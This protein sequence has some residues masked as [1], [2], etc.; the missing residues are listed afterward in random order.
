MTAR[1][2]VLLCAWVLW[3]QIVTLT[4]PPGDPSRL[5]LPGPWTLDSAYTFRATCLVVSAVKHAYGGDRPGPGGKY[6]YPSTRLD[7]W[8]LPPGVQPGLTAGG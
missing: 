1:R 2:Y 6:A 5:A 4:A 8:C 3:T 7:T